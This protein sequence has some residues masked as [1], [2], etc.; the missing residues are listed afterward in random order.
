V[1]AF[2]TIAMAIEPGGRELA[3]WEKALAGVKAAGGTSCGVAV[4]RL[5]QKKQ[6]VE[7]IIFITDEAENTPPLLAQ[8]L[9]AYCR[10]RGTAPNV[11]FVKTQGASEMLERQLQGMGIACDAFQFSGDYYA[12]PNLIPM[13]LQPS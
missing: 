10:E 2:D 6:Y 5:R 4:D 7:Q 1:Y 11:C 13:L 3:T 12:L 8:A 9:T